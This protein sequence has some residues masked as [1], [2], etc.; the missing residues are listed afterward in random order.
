MGLARDCWLGAFCFSVKLKRFN[1]MK[2][3]LTIGLSFCSLFFIY[4]FIA[5]A[6]CTSMTDYSALQQNYANRDLSGSGI[7]AEA[8]DTCLSQIRS[9]NQQ[10]RDQQTI[11]AKNAQQ[12]YEIKLAYFYQLDT[13]E[14]KLETIG[15]SVPGYAQCRIS[16]INCGQE[17]LI[18]SDPTTLD[19][20]VFLRL[21]GNK[22]QCVTDL[23]QCL[24]KLINTPQVSQTTQNTKTADQMCTDKFGQNYVSKGN[25]ICGCKDG[26]A[27]NNGLCVTY[28]QSCNLSYANSV[29]LKIDSSDGRRIC[30]CKDG[31]IW[32]SDKT[33]CIVAPITPVL[34][35]DQICLRDVGENTFWDGTVTN[36]NPEC[37]CKT[38]YVWKSKEQ[39]KGCI[40]APVAPEKT[41]DQVC[42]DTY[43]TNSYWY[44][45][46]DVQGKINCSCADG[47]QFN[48]DK[49]QCISI[50]VKSNVSNTVAAPVIKST[51]TETKE[52]KVKSTTSNNILT[53]S[54]STNLSTTSKKVEVK[55]KSF[56]SIIKSWFGFK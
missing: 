46:K 5:N 11:E 2:K 26:Y 17:L 55:H 30:D 51:P 16:D 53:I 48:Q 13:L 47:Y 8:L 38:G 44:G 15:G 21:M 52:I 35:N 40:L 45:T 20:N 25:S 42:K 19:P 49:T 14:K 9:Y 12:T 4:P 31:Y 41:N 7:E 50:P 10:L 27:Q 18:P 56:W 33:S 37:I 1:D 54:M 24:E 23:S 32:N 43:G 6:N 22:E 28:D 29:F 39:G 3:I 36:N 34:N